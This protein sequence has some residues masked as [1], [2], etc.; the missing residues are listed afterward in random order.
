MATTCKC[1]AVLL[2]GR[3]HLNCPLKADATLYAREYEQRPVA[4]AKPRV[5]LQVYDATLGC[6]YRV[7]VM[8]HPRRYVD[9]WLTEP[10]WRPLAWTDWRSS[11]RDAWAEACRANGIVN[12]RTGNPTWDGW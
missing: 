3:A 10:S 4:V 9:R 6:Q 8:P 7:L 11:A 5:R 1:G 2:Y 12:Q